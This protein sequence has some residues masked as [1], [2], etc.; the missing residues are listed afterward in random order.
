MQNFRL[1]KVPT[2]LIPEST[3]LDQKYSNIMHKYYNELTR[4]FI[5]VVAFSSS[6]LELTDASFFLPKSS[7]KSC[8]LLKKE[9]IFTFLKISHVDNILNIHLIG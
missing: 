4:Y 7:C 9:D 3:K 6:L 5:M 8:S 1:N 2:K